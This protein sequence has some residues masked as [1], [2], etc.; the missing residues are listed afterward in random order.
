VR[1]AVVPRIRV[2]VVDDHETVRRGICTLLR[3][4]PDIEVTC[5]VA[6][7]LQAVRK[8]KQVQPDVIVLD[9]T[10]PKLDGLKAAVRIR[11]VAPQTEI[12]FLS[13]HDSLE[14]VRQ[15]LRAGGRGYVVKSDAAKELIPAVRAAKNKERYVNTRFAVDL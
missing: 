8:A 14:S 12:V 5:D 13:Q 15:A 9:I 1:G 4:D 10:M 6:D 7:G 2:L 3:S 11:K